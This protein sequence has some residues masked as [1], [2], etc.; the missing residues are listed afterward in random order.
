VKALVLSG[1]GSKGAYEVGA[2]FYLCV[3]AARTYD[4]ICGVSVGALNGAFLAQWKAGDETTG[5]MKLDSFWAAINQSKVYKSW[6]GGYLA[7]LWKPSLYNSKPLS[8][9]V[10]SNLDAEAVRRSG[11]L[12]RVGAVDLNTGEYRL[13]DERHPKLWDTVLASAAYPAIL[14]P[15]KLESGLWIDG[16]V[17]DITPLGAAIQL[18]ATD[19]DVVMASPSA[20]KPRKAQGM[21]AIDIALRAIDILTDEVNRGDLAKAQLYNQLVESDQRPDKRYVKL[22]IIRPD[23]ELTSNSFDFSPSLLA[24]MRKRGYEDAERALSRA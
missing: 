13:F 20:V 17:R 5:A 12:L 18:G 16:G 22:T 7:A 8:D 21:N 2:I 9:L 1:G 23:T 10:H 14:S 6:F 3:V 11:K 24:S 15:V 19:I 4:V